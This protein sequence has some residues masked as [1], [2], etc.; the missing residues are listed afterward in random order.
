[1]KKVLVLSPHTDDAELGAGGLLKKLTDGGSDLLYVSF[2]I[3]GKSLP[4]G[5]DE[6][7]LIDEL[8]LA[9]TELGIIKEN[10]KIFNFEVRK[11]NYFRQEILEEL[12]VIRDNF[13]PELVLLPS[14]QD[15]HQD[16]IVIYQEGVRAFK[17]SC[18]LGYELI[19]NNLNFSGNYFYSIS[20]RELS[21]KMSAL[22]KYKSQ[23]YRKYMKPD[24]IESWAKTRGLQAGVDYAELFEVV[25]WI[26]R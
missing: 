11:L 23:A 2:S 1:M 21:Y 18:I 24:F 22:A 9:T 8:Y 4:D 20:N 25:R 14:S 19:W 17:H 26:Q 5:F 13:K 3:A 6:S 10:V 12:I 16:H 15:I 7:M